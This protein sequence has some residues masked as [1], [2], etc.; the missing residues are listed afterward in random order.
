MTSLSSRPRTFPRPED[1]AAWTRKWSSLFSITMVVVVTGLACLPFDHF[2]ASAILIE[3]LP[4]DLHRTIALL[5]IF[6]HGTGIMLVIFALLLIRRDLWRGTVRM[7]IAFMLAGG[8]VN[9][10]KLLVWRYR[11]SFFWPDIDANDRSWTAAEKAVSANGEWLWNVTDYATQSFPSGHSANAVIL[12]WFLSALYPSG[13]PLFW[14]LALVACLQRVLAHS[15]WP[16]DVAAG[17]LLGVAGTCIAL[18]VPLG[19]ETGRG[20]MQQEHDGAS[21]A[22]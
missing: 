17:A 21:Q 20:E 3:R 7:L 12:A 2:L 11:P 13:R 14:S 8:L 22:T 6:G 19:S 4:G 9:L 5:E 16:T 1:P 18:L 15:H 10:L